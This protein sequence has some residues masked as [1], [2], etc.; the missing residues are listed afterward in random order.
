M[1]VEMG[2]SNTTFSVK[3]DKKITTF[4]L[5]NID[6]TEYWGFETS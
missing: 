5:K 6:G 1:Y 3:K 4:L 2:P